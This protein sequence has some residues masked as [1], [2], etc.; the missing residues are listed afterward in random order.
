MITAK[1]DASSSTIQSDCLDMASWLSRAGNFEHAIAY[2]RLCWPK[3]RF[4]DGCVL[5]ADID[6]QSYNAWLRAFRGNRTLTQAVLNHRH[7]L[8]LFP[9]GTL[10]PS[11]E[12][13]AYLGQRLK[14]SWQ[15]KLNLD[16]PNCAATVALLDGAAQGI[17]DPFAYLVTF[18]VSRQEDIEKF[19]DKEGQ[20]LFLG[21]C[22]PRAH[23]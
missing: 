5:F 20:R 9:D 12:Q 16:F 21:A 7:L 18:F 6:G 2:A 23:L 11:R 13:L 8:E 1:P 14:A 15:T 19:N 3:F 22:H 10:E 4:H 17:D